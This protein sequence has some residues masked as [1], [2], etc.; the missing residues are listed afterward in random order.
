MGTDLQ[1]QTERAL[2]FAHQPDEF[3]TQ[4]EAFLVT[5]QDAYR[6]K[7]SETEQQL[8]V[9]ALCQSEEKFSIQE[10]L[11]ALDEIVKNPPLYEVDGPEG[12]VTQKWRGLPKLPDLVDA[13]LS[14][15][16]KLIQEA[17]RLKAEA[18][19]KQYRQLEKDRAEHPENFLGW[20]EFVT[21]AK[22]EHPEFFQGSV[23][24]R[25]GAKTP[26]A[27]EPERISPVLVNDELAARR[28]QQ[29]KNQLEEHERSKAK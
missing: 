27:M 2:I 22:Q 4:L 13:M 19:A 24:D 21:K 11:S 28:V 23:P 5:I 3:L 6:S 25:D 10:I 9:R 15:R 26:L 18:D 8:W 12:P 29:L 17:R 20:G 1:K 7:L 16:R 14:L